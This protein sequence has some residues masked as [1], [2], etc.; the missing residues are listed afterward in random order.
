MSAAVAAA[1]ARS[2]AGVRKTDWRAV[3]L[4]VAIGAVGGVV[5]SYLRLP[6]AW[7]LGPMVAVTAAATLR[8]KVVV[9]APLRTVC[10]GML[11]LLLGSTFTPEI[12]G[13]VGEWAVTLGVMIA[14]VL[15][16]AFTIVLIFRRVFGFDPVTAYFSGM[17]GGIAEM[18]IIGAAMGGDGRTIALFHGARV[19]IV[20]L[21][22]PMGFRF[23]AGY[24]PQSIAALAGAS[25]PMGAFDAVILTLGGVVGYFVAERCRVPAPTMMGPLLASG[26]LHVTGLT[27][28]SLPAALVIFGQLGVGASIGCRFSGVRPATILRTLGL[29]TV[30]VLVM[31]VLTLMFAFGLSHVTGLPYA[32]LVLAYAPG[33]IT[34]MCLVAYVLGFDVTFVATH[35][36]LRFVFVIIVAPLAAKF[37]G[38][39]KPRAG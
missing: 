33:G 37:M 35:H 12:F 5:F 2:V 23:L 21:C 9:P 10:N 28:A 26:L 13:R 31:L 14:Y 15:L 16:I 11:G 17:P 8:A 18:T 24:E 7:M 22:V 3:A 20:A 27:H 19:L 39:L 4:A 34:E 29:A 32:E 36:V 6:L 38:A 30:T 25:V 1:W